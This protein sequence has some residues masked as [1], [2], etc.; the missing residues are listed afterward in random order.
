[1]TTER[2]THLSSEERSKIRHFVKNRL[3]DCEVCRHEF[4]DYGWSLHNEIS[5]ADAGGY[6]P[7]SEAELSFAIVSCDLCGNTKWLLRPILHGWLGVPSEDL[8]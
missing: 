2:R 1:M 4:S 8:A 5:Y 7:G 3:A 6:P